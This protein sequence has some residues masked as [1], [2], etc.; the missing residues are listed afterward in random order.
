[1]VLTPFLLCWGS[2]LNVLSHRLIRGTNIVFPGSSC[3]LCQK[4]IPWYDLVPVFSWLTLRGKCRQCQGTISILYPLIELLTP[5]IMIPLI[6]WVPL[7]YLPAYFLFFSALIVTIRSD[8]EHLLISRFTT[9]FLIPVGLLLSSLNALPITFWESLVGTAIGYGFLFTIAAVFRWITGKDGMGQGDLE[10]LA[11]IGS[12]TG[13]F[14]CWVS[15]LI[16]SILGTIYGLTRLPTSRK[17]LVKIP[18]GPFLALGAIS[19]VLW[20]Q[21]ILDFLFGL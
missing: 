15:L 4:N 16:G 8:I 21:P 20:Q 9:L 11:F 10:L 18:F 13:I 5:L 2:F 7:R 3:P 6:L 17:P 12:F 14:G 19:Y 1:M